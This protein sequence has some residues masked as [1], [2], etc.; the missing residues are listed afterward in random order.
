MSFLFSL[1]LLVN[2]HFDLSTYQKSVVCKFEHEIR[3]QA[4]ANNLEP[5]LLTA[6]IFVESSFHP[7]ATSS[8]GACGLTQVVPRW[9][10]F[11]ETKGVKYTCKQLKDPVTSIKVGAQILSYNIRVYAK[12]NKNKGLCFYNAGTKCITKKGFYKRLG[13]VKKV[14]RIYTILVG[15]C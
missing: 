12:G 3:K 4:K 1:C 10:G 14:K 6:L 7:E 2:Q 8:A 15:G 13:Y 11:K 5:E 9:T